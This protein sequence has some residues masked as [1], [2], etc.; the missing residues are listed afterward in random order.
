MKSHHTGAGAQNKIERNEIK[1]YLPVIHTNCKKAG[2][3]AF[4]YALLGLK[5]GVL[6]V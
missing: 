1:R 5:L 2:K 4:S 3:E 6:V